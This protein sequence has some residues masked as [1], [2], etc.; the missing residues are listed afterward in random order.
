MKKVIAKGLALTFIAIAMLLAGCTS[1]PLNPKFIPSK[2]YA[3]DPLKGEPL[4]K[5]TDMSGRGFCSGAVISKDYV[6]TAAHCVKD[7]SKY[8]KTIKV[9]DPTETFVGE[10]RVAAYNESTDLALITGN[11]EHFNS[12]PVT[13]NM[14]MTL[15]LLGMAQGAVNVCGFPRGGDGLCMP[16]RI[17]GQYWFSFAGQG[18]MLPGMSGGPVIEPLTGSIIAVNYGVADSILL[19]SPTVELFRILGIEVGE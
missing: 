1:A 18:F 16:L 8:I 4:V 17:Q 10:A 13:V 19:F 5:L 12:I 15:N 9:V 7:R 3:Q 14:G 6:L 11:F 2:S